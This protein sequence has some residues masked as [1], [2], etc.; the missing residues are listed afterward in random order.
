MHVLEGKSE[1]VSEIRRL[2]LM[3]TT[4]M[5]FFAATD[6][7]VRRIIQNWA[8]FSSQDNTATALMWDFAGRSFEMNLGK[9]DIFL[10]LWS[11]WIDEWGR[12]KIKVNSIL[13]R[14]SCVISSIP[15]CYMISDRVMVGHIAQA[16]IALERKKININSSYQG[17]TCRK[18]KEMRAE[19]GSVLF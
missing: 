2:T 18:P 12:L 16:R 7:A 8:R 1:V 3:K 5:H 14:S 10:Y 9:R 15:L 6:S 13:R 11:W 4:K 19:I 17:G